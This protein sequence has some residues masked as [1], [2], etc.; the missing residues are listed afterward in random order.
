MIN[1]TPVFIIQ[2]QLNFNSLCVYESIFY[3]K[4]KIK[5]SKNHFK[6]IHNKNRKMS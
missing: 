2:K 3:E 5:I 6:P 1:V 4:K